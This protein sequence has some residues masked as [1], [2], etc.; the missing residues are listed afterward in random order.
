MHAS[1]LWILLALSW[2]P[3]VQAAD[4]ERGRQ[5]LEENCLSC[6]PAGTFARPGSSVQWLEQLQNRVQGCSNSH[7]PYLDADEI[8]DVSACLN[9]DFYRTHN[10]WVEMFHYID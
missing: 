1:S 4:V 3:A 10:Y 6:H 7:V 2:L 8:E 9:A 5:I